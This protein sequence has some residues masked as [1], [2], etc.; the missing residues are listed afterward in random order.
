MG[1][2]LVTGVTG[3]IGS[4]LLPALKPDWEVIGIS[5]DR[6][7]EEAGSGSSFHLCI[8]FSQ[9]WDIQVLP[10]KIDAVV[11]LAQS[12]HFR[13]FPESALDIFQ[14][15]TMS[16]VRL[17]DYARRAGAS[18]FVLAS[19]GG[20]YGP[21]D[22]ELSE[23]M[24]ILAKG[25]LGF[26][27]GTKLCAEVMAEN[28]ASYFNVIILRLFFV[29][30][31]GQRKSML[32]PRLVES[33]V[34][35]RPITLQGKNGIRVNPTY[36]SDAVAAICRSLG[37]SGHHKINVAGPEVLSLR[38]IGEVIGKVVGKKPRFECQ[39][40]SNP[41]HIIGDICRM[42]EMLGPPTVRFEEGIRSYLEGTKR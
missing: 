36:V 13:D 30:G 38:E 42:T 40:G 39:S 9:A 7:A 29:Y 20:I 16:T 27:L 2:C 22:R 31:P 5:R 33:V 41:Q 14:V 8:D 28:Y 26:Y 15:N 37:L 25:D 10:S 4:N 35:G 3:V 34:E 23:D 17:L 19:S 6:L 1:R 24:E 21:R 12:R 18:T 11:H 32:I